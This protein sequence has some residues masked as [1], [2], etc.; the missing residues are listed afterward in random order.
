[1]KKQTYLLTTIALC[2]ATILTACKAPEAS[3][4]ATA[5]QPETTAPVPAKA[6]A[7]PAP[8]QPVPAKAVPAKAVPANEAPKPAKAVPAKQLSADK[9]SEKKIGVRVA[10]WEDSDAFKN[11]YF[12]DGDNFKP[13][14]VYKRMFQNRYEVPMAENALEL[15]RKTGD[16]YVSLTRI[17]LLDHGECAL[18][19]L[20]DYDPETAPDR[21]L[22][23]SLDDKDFPNGSVAVFNFSGKKLSGSI[24]VKE[25]GNDTEKTRFFSLLPGT[26]SVSAP[27]EDV[28]QIARLNIV[29]SS[30][31]NETA[32]RDVFSGDFVV[33][34]NIRYCI[35]S[36]PPTDTKE[37][38]V[39]NF[40]MIKIR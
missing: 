27:A 28:G 17:K 39:P 23:V 35:F 11:L 14:A 18:L 16:D 9:K 21:V 5:A 1:M 15:F 2:C 8:A 26:H 19:F 32:G 31:D 7:K 4:K 37:N 33:S 30:G 6:E 25:N 36:L 24:V 22:L 38:P 20:A 34:K 40:I 13:F 10:S 29:E 12:K 3:D